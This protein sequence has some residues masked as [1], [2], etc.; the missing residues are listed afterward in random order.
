MK[1]G[2]TPIIAIIILL[3]ITI[4]LA[5]AAWTY[6]QGFLF[7]QIS[8]SFVIPTG[9]AYCEKG[10]ISVY[11]LNTGYDSILANE[12]FIVHTIDGIVVDL[13]D[14][15]L[16]E[17]DAGLALQNDSS[18]TGWGAGYYTVRLGTQSTIVNPRVSC[19]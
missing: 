18:G 2:I 10:Q 5:G 9:G 1:K 17:G 3:L 16:G 11:V 15:N 8:K 12:D 4:A 14:F 6:L 13:E 7:S 19:T